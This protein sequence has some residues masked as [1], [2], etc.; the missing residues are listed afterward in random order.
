MAY[1]P[2]IEELAREAKDFAVK[3]IEDETGVSLKRLVQLA[4]AYQERRCV[5]VEK[6]PE[7]GKE[8]VLQTI[9]GCWTNDTMIVLK[10]SD[11]K[12]KNEG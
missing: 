9:Q 8:Y 10:Q 7:A 12:T 6:P 1:L 4:C 5:I 2:S 11:I 3:M